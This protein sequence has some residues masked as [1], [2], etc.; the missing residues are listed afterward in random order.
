M[1]TK[2]IISRLVAEMTEMKKVIVNGEFEIALPDHRAARPEWYEPK[3]WEKPRLR[4]MS[5]NISSGDVMYYVGAEEG[6]FAALCQMWGAEVVVFEPNPK[7]WSHFPLLWSANNLDLPMVCIPG[8]ASDKINNLSRIYYNEWPPEVNNVIE[9]AHGFKELY[10]EGES[11][12]Q[13]TIDSCVYD[14]GIKPPTAIS[15]DVEGSEWRVLGGAE[16]VMR[17][18]KPKIWLSGHPEFMLQQWDESL[19]NLRQWIKGLGYTEIILDYQ[20][21]VH[22]YYESC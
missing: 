21:E 6:E 18:F 11:Y 3:G 5:E 20:H 12:G 9:A 2:S 17:K 16:K 15:L 22:L 13:I 14:H 10:L 19:Y 7:V 4:H 8:F 1:D